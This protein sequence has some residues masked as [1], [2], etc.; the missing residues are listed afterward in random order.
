MRGV[1]VK[2]YLFNNYTI[3]QIQCNT[4]YVIEENDN[5]LLL[6]WD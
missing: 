2:P 1:L 5:Y 3:K 6:Y 4:M